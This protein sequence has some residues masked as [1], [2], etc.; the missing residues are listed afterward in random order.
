M[1]GSEISFVDKGY[2]LQ[3]NN[4]HN[5]MYNIPSDST[6]QTIAV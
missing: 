3:H 6:K 2:W 4:R 1:L 5:E